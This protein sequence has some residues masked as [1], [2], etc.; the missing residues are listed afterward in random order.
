MTWT[1]AQRIRAVVFVAVA[2]AMIILPALR[3]ADGGARFGWR[4]FSFQ[5]PFPEFTLVDESGSHTEIDPLP[6]IGRLRGDVPFVSA[7]PPHLC[8]AVPGTA[9]VITEL[10]DNQSEFVCP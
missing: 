9:R 3:A 10:G 6:Y 8:Q 1:V 2:V 7:L 4:M 5:E